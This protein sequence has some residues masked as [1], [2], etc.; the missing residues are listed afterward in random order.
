MSMATF[1]IRNPSGIGT[2]IVVAINGLVYVWITVG[3]LQRAESVF[4]FVFWLA[5]FVLYMIILVAVVYRALQAPT[6]LQIDNKQI[7]LNGRTVQADEVKVLLISGYFR[8]VVGIK[9]VGRRI[10]PVPLSFRFAEEE[11]RDIKEIERWAEENRVKLSYT[12]FV[13]WL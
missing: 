9:P 2:V 5:V 11:D 13:K 7:S 3:I 6:V 1:A 12:P 4:S 10:V 8:P